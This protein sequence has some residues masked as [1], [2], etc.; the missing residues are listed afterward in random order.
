MK[1]TV[2]G[3]WSAGCAFGMNFAFAQR[4][5]VIFVEYFIRSNLGACVRHS[6]LERNDVDV[7]YFVCRKEF[8]KI[9]ALHVSFTHVIC[10]IKFVEILRYFPQ[11]HCVTL[12]INF[13]ESKTRQITKKT[14]ACTGICL[15][16]K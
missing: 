2:F 10:M 16:Q 15:E 1:T 7:L 14:S 11:T 6:H 13:I 9:M 5:L 8:W 4:Q 12:S 3:S